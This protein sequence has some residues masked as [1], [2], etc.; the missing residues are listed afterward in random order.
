MKN[1]VG[2]VIL[3]LKNKNIKPKQ[4]IDRCFLATMSIGVDKYFT[5]FALRFFTL[6]YKTSLFHSVSQL[7]F[8]PSVE[9]YHLFI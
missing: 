8:P 6:M 3:S 2:T 9:K 1:T 7:N 5:F 4:E